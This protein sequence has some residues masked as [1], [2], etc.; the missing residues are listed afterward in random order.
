MMKYRKYPDGR[1]VANRKTWAEVASPQ[2]KKPEPKGKGP[3]MGDDAEPGPSGA[4]SEE[5]T[6]GGAADVNTVPVVEEAKNNNQPPGTV[7]PELD[8]KVEQAIANAI[9]TQKRKQAERKVAMMRVLS[10][11]NAM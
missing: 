8:A 4:V 11:G 10:R 7:D 5:S 2:G 9:E 1:K 6:Q 3:D